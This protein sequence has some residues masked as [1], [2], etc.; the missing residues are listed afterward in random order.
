MFT[1]KI[2]EGNGMR[3]S[4]FE[5]RYRNIQV[6]DA[7]PIP[8]KNLETL[9]KIVRVVAL[10]KLTKAQVKLENEKGELGNATCQSAYLKP[11]ATREGTVMQRH[12][13]GH[14]VQDGQSHF[15]QQLHW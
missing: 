3:R 4:P 10:R 9:K 1:I 12:V 7:G 2:Q 14:I 11:N 15:S 13:N 5:S 8:E 6:V